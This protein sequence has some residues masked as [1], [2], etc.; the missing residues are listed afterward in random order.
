MKKFKQYLPEG[1]GFKDSD[2]EDNNS[3]GS[4]GSSEEDM[5]N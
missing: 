4:S 1:T 3:W 5:D 2:S